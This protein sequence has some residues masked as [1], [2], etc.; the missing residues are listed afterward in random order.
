VDIKD[1]VKK[2]DNEVCLT[3]AL[4]A[5]GVED[6]LTRAKVLTIGLWWPYYIRLLDESHIPDMISLQSAHGE[7]QVIDRDAQTLRAHFNAGHEAFGVFHE[8]K[9]V[10]QALMRS[11]VPPTADS[12]ALARD[13]NKVSIMGGVVVAPVARGKGMLDS[14]IG[15]WH[16]RAAKQG[17]DI[18]HARVRPEN[19]KSW[20]VFMRNGLSITGQRPDD[21]T[22]D[23]FMLHKPVSG[24]FY[25]QEEPTSPMRGNGYD[26]SAQ[27]GRGLIATR[28][29]PHHRQFAFARPTAP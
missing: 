4:C 23:V 11:E 20:M 12:G 5:M 17:A 19:E 29:N 28:W 1:Q 9:L 22:H 14:M 15:L 13:F 25:L 26:I 27:L 10:A 16:T 7:G 8:G 3:A 2:N 6:E 21:P 24:C 18:L